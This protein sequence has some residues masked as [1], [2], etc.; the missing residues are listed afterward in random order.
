MNLKGNLL[1]P[2]QTLGSGR[3]RQFILQDRKTRI[4]QITTFCPDIIGPGPTH[5]DLIEDEALVLLDTGIPTG[6]AKKFFYGA[7]SQT[8]PSEVQSLPD[9]YS[10]QEL[11]EGLKLAGYSIKDIDLLVIS[12]G[13][14]DHF[15]M[16]RWIS[17]QAGC[18]ATAHVL[19]TSDICNPWEMLEMW[20]HLRNQTQAMGMPQP[21]VTNI[22]PG[23]DFET[24]GPEAAGFSMTLN[25][26]IS[27]DGPLK[28]N[29]ARFKNIEVKHLPGHS[30]GGIGLIVGQEGSEKVL[31]CGDVLL[32]PI[33]PHPDDL[34]TYLRTLEDL[35]NLEGIVLALPAHGKAIK[36]I[37]A[38]V[39][40]LQ[41]YHHKRLKITYKACRKPCS[42]WDIATLPGYFDIPVDPKKFNPLAGS[43]ALTHIEILHM[44]QGLERVSIQNGVHFFN[45]TGEPFE[46]V[47]ERVLEMVRDRDKN[48]IMRY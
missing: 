2:T 35:K 36:N 32:T 14:P 43:E 29:N 1:K 15:F 5:L 17:D 10:K 13:H 33:T 40:F 19:D 39:S 42:V 47:Y 48:P 4:T 31:L 20:L 26:P 21:R 16:G 34:L 44:V 9:D 22:S 18:P 8:I 23:L 28:L 11:L 3:V 41:R 46:D 30:P 25:F 6:L 7:R 37:K 24:L 45:N 38:R 12:H 27:Q